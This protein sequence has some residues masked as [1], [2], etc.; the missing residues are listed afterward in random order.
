MSKMR[1][2]FTVDGQ[3]YS[4]IPEPHTDMVFSIIAEENGV[5]I[6]SFIF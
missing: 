4:Y 1:R 6:C 2:G 5:I 3:K